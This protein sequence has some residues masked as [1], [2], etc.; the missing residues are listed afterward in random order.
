MSDPHLLLPS[1]L[2]LLPKSKVSP[3]SLSFARATLRTTRLTRL[4]P[5][6]AI[7]FA[8]DG[9]KARSWLEWAASAKF[10]PGCLAVYALHRL[11]GWPKQSPIETVAFKAVLLPVWKV[12]LSAKGDGSLDGVEVDLACEYHFRRRLMPYM[13]K[14]NGRDS[15]DVGRDFSGIQDGA[16]RQAVLERT[17]GS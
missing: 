15:P 7:P 9:D 4:L 1:L 13:G 2:P 14:L 11:F 10:G 17:L 6:T 8:L 16:A 12:D 5:R 3:V